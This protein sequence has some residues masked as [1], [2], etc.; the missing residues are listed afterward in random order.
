MKAKPGKPPKTKFSK[1]MADRSITTEELV[2]KLNNHIKRRRLIGTIMATHRNVRAWRDG[3]RLPNPVFQV[4][5]C[6]I[7]QDLN[8]SKLKHLL[9]T[10]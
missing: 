5:L 8:R 9:E 10:E 7:I 3:S 4:L 6:Q 1:W 2:S